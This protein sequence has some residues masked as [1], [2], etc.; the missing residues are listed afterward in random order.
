MIALAG[1][2]VA[3]YPAT[4]RDSA[5]DTYF[6]TRVPDPYRW[7]ERID[8]PKTKHWV[9]AQSHLTEQTL[10]DMPDRARMR[11]LFVSLIGAKTDSLPQ[12]GGNVVA[13]TRSEGN[14]RLPVVVLRSAGLQR[15]VID[16]NRRWPDG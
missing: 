7:L 13:F 2:F 5:S 9:D 3:T 4:P 6:G 14:G 11:A 16:P 15:V 8:D 10:A 1:S 12:L